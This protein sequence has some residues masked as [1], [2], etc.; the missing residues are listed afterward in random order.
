MVSRLLSRL[1]SPSLSPSLTFSH[2]P[3]QVKLRPLREAVR[4]QLESSSIEAVAAEVDESQTIL[5]SWLD[6]DWGGLQFACV[7]SFE[8]LLVA[9]LEI[10]LRRWLAGS[11]DDALD[12]RRFECQ[13]CGKV[14]HSSDSLRK[15]EM[16]CGV[17]RLRQRAIEKARNVRKRGSSQCPY[18]DRVVT[19]GALVGHIEA[20]LKLQA[21]GDQPVLSDGN[22]DSGNGG[23]VTVGGGSGGDGYGAVG[24]HEPMAV[25]TGEVSSTAAQ[26]LPSI[27]NGEPI[28]VVEVAVSGRRVSVRMD[29]KAGVGLHALDSR[30]DVLRA[31]N[32]S[33][34]WGISFMESGSRRDRPWVIDFATDLPSCRDAPDQKPNKG[35]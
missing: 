31:P 28:V 24:A 34:W 9:P 33:G 29:V 5:Q 6:N 22:E 2:L 25:G 7:R 20:C 11:Y 8:K 15:H 26:S 21:R 27:V 16:A 17:R 13:L 23:S 12:E 4:S 3:S 35:R 10:D 14:M 19:G 30:L 32:A 18:C 1:L